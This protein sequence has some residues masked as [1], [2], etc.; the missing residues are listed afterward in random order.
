VLIGNPGK[1]KEKASLETL[2][3]PSHFPNHTTNPN[4]NTNTNT[5]P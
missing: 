4:T 5:I 1:K 2:K 3:S